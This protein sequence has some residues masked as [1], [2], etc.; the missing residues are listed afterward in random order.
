MRFLVEA[1]EV[2]DDP[3]EIAELLERAGKAAVLGGDV[4][5]AEPLLRDAITRRDEMGDRSGAARAT[6]LL[7]QGFVNDWRSA[8]AIAIL[9]PAVEAYGDLAD[10]PALAAI[11]HQLARGYWFGDDTVRAIELADR[12]IGRAER[13]EAVELIADALITKGALLD[14]RRGRTR[15]SGSSRR[16]SG[17]PRRWACARRW[18]AAC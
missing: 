8:D 15:A 2:T 12:A 14:V 1:I 17:L 13:I 5:Q 4:E 7:G 9:E 11:E 16:A 3:A 18:S 6:A 10:D